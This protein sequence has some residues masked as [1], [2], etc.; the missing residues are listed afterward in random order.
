MLT[1]ALLA[2]GLGENE[3][4][5]LKRRESEARQLFAVAMSPGARLGASVRRL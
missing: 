5:E 2:G 3:R 4:E 1:A